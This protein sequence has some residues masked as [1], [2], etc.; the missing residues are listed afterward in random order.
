MSAL[1]PQPIRMG[2]SEPRIVLFECGAAAADERAHQVLV[3]AGS[4]GEVV[5]D[6][7]SG[8]APVFTS[9]HRHDLGDGVRVEA[10]LD[11][12]T[13]SSSLM[14]NTSLPSTCRGCV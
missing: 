8:S 11:S 5:L 14:V 9:L 1:A 2:C 10:E 13:P 7:Y 3:P 6:Q 4:V 12:F